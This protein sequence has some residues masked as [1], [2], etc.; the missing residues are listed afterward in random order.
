[1]AVP[2]ATCAK[3]KDIKVLIEWVKRG[4]RWFAYDT[5]PGARGVV[6]TEELHACYRGRAIASPIPEVPRG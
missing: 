4:D 2:C 6:A 1:M 5:T 3:D